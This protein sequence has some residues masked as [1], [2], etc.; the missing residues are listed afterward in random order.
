M[1][2]S[3]AGDSQDVR[4]EGDADRIIKVLSYLAAKR[5]D[6]TLRGKTGEA[7]GR[8][9]LARMMT[10]GRQREDAAVP[11]TGARIVLEGALSDGVSTLLYGASEVRIEAVSGGTCIFFDTLYRK[12]S[13]SGTQ[14]EIEVDFPRTLCIK[15][16]RRSPREEPKIPEF[17]SVEMKPPKSP[18]DGRLYTFSV[19]N[20]S[21]HGLGVLI[22]ETEEEFLAS[23]RP[24]DLLPRVT[25]YARDSLI[26]VEARV[27]HITQIKGGREKGNYILGLESKELI[28][29]S[30]CPD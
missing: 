8:F 12:A 17:V 28:E 3:R 20:T 18:G 23:I 1:N 4:I 30:K 16:A 9:K 5:M 2:G 6:V 19:V 29:S 25:L 22:P 27:V 13:S 21:E 7:L 11:E 26:R 14:V 15:E 10:G 24:G